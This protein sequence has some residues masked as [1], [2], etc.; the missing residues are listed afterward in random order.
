MFGDGGER[1]GKRLGQFRDHGFAAGQAGQ[2]GA[3]RGVSEGA[4]GG[5]ER[6]S[7]IVNHVV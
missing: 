7:E 2:D 1:H 5:V 4:K 6:R 3:A